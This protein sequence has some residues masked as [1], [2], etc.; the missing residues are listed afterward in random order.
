[1]TS[2]SFFCSFIYV[3]SNDNFQKLDTRDVV[4]TD[5]VYGQLPIQHLK[6]HRKPRNGNLSKE[7]K[8]ENDV[9]TE[10]RGDIERKFG[11]VKT[12][13]AVLA[14]IFQHGEENFNIELRTGT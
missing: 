5:G 14:S 12:K 2:F 9:I 3:P 4:V 11:H 10:F 7:Q 13:F 1:M 8:K 6:P